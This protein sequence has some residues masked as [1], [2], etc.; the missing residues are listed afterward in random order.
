MIQR[1]IISLVNMITRTFFRRIDVVGRENVPDTGPVIFAGNHPNALMD[2]WLLT[3][4]CGRW[5]LHFMVNAKLWKYRVLAPLLDVSGAVPV[6]RREESDGEVDNSGAF[7]RLYE[8][9]EGGN[10][11]GVFPEGISH[12]DSQLAEL[13]TGTARIALAVASRGKVKVTI[14]PCGL[15]YIHRHR[16]RSQVLL[17]FGVPLVIDEAWIAQYADDE[18]SAVR[19]L[20]D[21]L[22][23]ALR[24]VTLNAPDW[25]T[26]R[27]VQ[28]TRRLYKPGDAHLSPGT[29]V[30]LSRRFAAAYANAAGDPEIEKLRS[31]VEDYQSRLDVLGLKDHQLRKT[32]SIGFAFRRLAARV[33][34][35]ALLTPLAVPGMLL[36]LPVG[37]VAATLG[38]KLSYEMDDVA[39]LKVFATLALLPLLYL[40]IG[41]AVSYYFGVGWAITAVVFLTLSFSVSIWLIEAQAYLFG[42]ML[43]ILRRTRLR[44]EIN[45][46]Q[47]IR[48]RLVQEV[49]D[50]ADSYADPD[51]PR[52]FDRDDFADLQDP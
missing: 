6:Y 42:S 52:I 36:H 3:S 37:W 33:L 24:A 50:R 49:R 22:A 10:C 23:D 51:R 19:A 14:V 46:L 9:I 38:E 28:A 11:M 32:V 43:S 39:T 40:A 20:T 1:A 15:N 34:L 21:T 29:Y 44:S 48:K 18:Q 45:D 16:F 41:I 25:R 7:S 17:E 47:Q 5:P 12:T 30:E 2:G 35:M 4:Q 27:F 26:L 31:E 8:V 13:K